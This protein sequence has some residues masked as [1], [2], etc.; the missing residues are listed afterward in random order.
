MAGEEVPDDQS[1]MESREEADD[2][3]S[4]QGRVFDLQ[5]SSASAVQA[6][7]PTRFEYFEDDGVIWGG[8][9][10]D[11]VTI[12]KMAGK[13]YGTSIELAYVHRTLAGNV[14]FGNATST[15]SVDPS[16]KFRLTEHFK[17]VDGTDQLSICCEI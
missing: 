9:A 7:A 3:F 2:S 16:G 12:G 13:R 8:Y 5:S 4:L 10:G 11:T 6:G 17:G 14:V 1:E 15:I